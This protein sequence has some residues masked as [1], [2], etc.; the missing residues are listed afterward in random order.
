MSIT[1]YT[2]LQSAVA[3][4]LHRDDLTNSIPLFIQLAEKQMSRHLRLKNQE[5]EATGVATTTI[6]LPSDYVE[7]IS[8]T[9]E[10]GGEHYPLSQRDRYSATV[11]NSSSAIASYYTIEGG[12]IVI[13]PPPASN[14]NYTLQYYAEV[15]PLSG[16]APTNWL[17]TAHPD[18]YF[19]ATLIHSAPH[20]EDDARIATWDAMYTRILAAIKEQNDNDRWSGSPMRARAGM[21]CW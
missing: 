9:L 7:A 20:L 3:N 12:N 16:G 14:T 13:A 8:L 11:L 21:S 5:T 2:D 4:I 6:A 19:Y 18:L 10:V 1:N 15:T 17:I